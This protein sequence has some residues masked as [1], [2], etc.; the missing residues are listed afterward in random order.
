M[1]P[2]LESLLDRLEHEVGA[3]RLMSEAEAIREASLSQAE[4]YLVLSVRIADLFQ[5]AR[6]F[7][8]EGSSSSQRR[9]FWI[10]G[11]RLTG[12]VIWLQPAVTISVNGGP[13]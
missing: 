9:R 8:N 4:E 1:N 10:L 12:K 7:L 13:K 2:V 6:P 5:L 3:F 11:L